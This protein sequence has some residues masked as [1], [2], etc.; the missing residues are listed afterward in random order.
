MATDRQFHAVVPR[1]PATD[2]SNCLFLDLRSGEGTEMASHTLSEEGLAAALK[3]LSLLLGCVRSR[4]MPTA[5][6][7]CTIPPL[8][9]IFPIKLYPQSPYFTEASPPPIPGPQVVGAISSMAKFSVFEV[10]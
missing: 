4:D 2:R 8:T 10:S 6:H 3:P 1:V 5:F 7:L 9:D